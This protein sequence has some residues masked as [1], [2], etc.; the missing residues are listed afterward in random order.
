MV[1]FALKHPKNTPEDVGNSHTA[2]EVQLAGTACTIAG[3][4]CVDS[5]E[6][7]CNVDDIHLHNIHFSIDIF[8][9]S[10][11]VYAVCVYTGFSFKHGISG[12]R[13]MMHC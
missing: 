13:R 5:L 3:D 8:C 12:I 11:Y 10:G 1:M 2:A 6:N 9:V 7:K 4:R